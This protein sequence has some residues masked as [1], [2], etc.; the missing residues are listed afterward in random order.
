M[1][2]TCPVRL[3][4]QIVFAC[5]LGCGPLLATPAVA[6]T[7]CVYT[8]TELQNALTTAQTNGEDDVI[9]ITTGTYVAPS[10]GFSYQAGTII[11]DYHALSLSGGWYGRFNAP[12][13]QQVQDPLQTV[14][15]GGSAQRVLKIVV[16]EADVNSNVSVRLLTFANGS[17][18]SL[19]G[20]LSLAGVNGDFA[21][22]WTIERNAFLN[23][24]AAHGGGLGIAENNAAATAHVRVINNLFLLNRATGNYGA[25][26]I[27]LDGGYGIYLTNNT[28][29]N[30]STAATGGSATGGIYVT[31]TGSV[32]VIVNN[33]LWGNDDADL[34]V[35][36]GSS[37]Y[38]L[39]HNNIG[40]LIGSLAGN[41]AGNI[42]I[43]PEYADPLA[44]F[45]YDF[46]PR[47]DSPLV[48]A[49]QS[50]TLF[51]GWYL[52]SYDLNGG[53][54]TVG[55]VDIG[56]YEEDLIFAGGFETPAF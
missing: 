4:A 19:G 28:V 38:S 51:S 42:S 12:C 49:G 48:D 50:P 27:G 30:N 15:D 2:A 6:A 29:L 20:G 17:S 32:R 52:P 54:R 16:R 35:N 39:M 8:S 11:G 33:N 22:N 41:S 37:G 1:S 56:A 5:V 44:S 14:L 21:G 31:G 45:D 7:F 43:T 26:Q 25:A 40:M 53:D 55:Q 34:W 23:N 47:R 10:G 46:A 3:A 36:S 9:K 13:S 24:Q 18:T